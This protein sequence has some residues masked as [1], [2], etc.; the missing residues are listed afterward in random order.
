MQAQQHGVSIYSEVNS[1]QKSFDAIWFWRKE[2]GDKIVESALM[3]GFAESAANLTKDAILWT[4][5][6]QYRS[7]LVV[8]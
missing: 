2:D 3:V 1:S 8:K 5:N 6:D 4:K 7:F